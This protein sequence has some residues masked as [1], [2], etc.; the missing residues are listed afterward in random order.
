MS[1]I[2]GVSEATRSPRGPLR[3]G[4]VGRGFA[5]YFPLPVSISQGHLCRGWGGYEAE[6][7]GTGVAERDRKGFKGR[8]YKD[9]NGLPT[10]GYGH[11]LLQSESFPGGLGSAG[12]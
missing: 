11:R 7:C 8:T 1:P 5:D 3:S 10:I 4:S 2:C 6:Q 9:A 12:S